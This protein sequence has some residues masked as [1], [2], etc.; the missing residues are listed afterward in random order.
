M[1]KVDFS[2]NRFNGGR[3]LDFSPN[4]PYNASYVESASSPK[5]YA[6]LSILSLCFTVILSI[7]KKYS[8]VFFGI[9]C[10]ANLSAILAV[11]KADVII[12]RIRRLLEYTWSELGSVRRWGKQPSW[13]LLVNNHIIIRQ[14]IQSCIH[15]FVYI[16]IPTLFFKL[17]SYIKLLSC[18]FFS[19]KV[20][21]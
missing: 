6:P 10:F 18:I 13:K 15:A 14:K 9:S 4:N 2:N 3:H 12:P 16:I 11:A 7:L 20:V 1:I 17:L 21:S 19:C 5:L 8:I